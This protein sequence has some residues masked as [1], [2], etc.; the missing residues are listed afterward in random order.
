MFTFFA[1]ALIV[2][3]ALIR[4]VPAFVGFLILAELHRRQ[5]HSLSAVELLLGI[6]L[7][8]ALAMTL[9][10]TNVISLYAWAYFVLS[11]AYVS[12]SSDTKKVDSILNWFV[13]VRTGV[14]PDDM[15]GDDDHVE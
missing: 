7:P 5:G 4:R 13:R 10:S 15:L 12:L 8:I 11:Y 14:A 2:L 3:A 1:A 9:V 6:S